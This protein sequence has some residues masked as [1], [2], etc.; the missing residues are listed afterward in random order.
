MKNNELNFDY[1]EKKF[2]E[3]KDDEIFELLNIT[4]KTARKAIIKG[5]FNDTEK[6]FIGAISNVKMI[7]EIMKENFNDLISQSYIYAYAKSEKYPLYNAFQIAYYASLQAYRK[8]IDETIG[9]RSRKRIDGKRVEQE[10][11]LN[12]SLDDE[13]NM[14]MKTESE[15]EYK[16]ADYIELKIDMERIL[17]DDE[18]SIVEYRK[19][20]YTMEEIAIIKQTYKMDISRKLEKIRKK[21]IAYK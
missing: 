9:K 20:G 1:T 14:I 19:E 10:R 11:H 15:K 3:L 8:L 18:L 12:A 6:I 17:N 5:K 21:M 2:S 4:V 7:D 16:S 13:S